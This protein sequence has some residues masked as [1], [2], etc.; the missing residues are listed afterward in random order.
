MNKKILNSFLPIIFTLLIPTTIFSMTKKFFFSKDSMIDVIKK[1]KDINIAK[2]REEILKNYNLYISQ[3]PDS[4]SLKMVNDA[5]KNLTRNSIDQIREINQRINQQ[6]QHKQQEQQKKKQEEEKK[7]QAEEQRKRLEQEKKQKEE[8]KKVAKEFENRRKAE[9]QRREKERIERERKAKEEVEKKK[10]E[11]ELKKKT[12]EEK[13]KRI[14]EL[15][16]SLEFANNYQEIKFKFDNKDYRIYT[17]ESETEQSKSSIDNL[18]NLI[19]GNKAAE[20]IKQVLIEGIKEKFDSIKDQ[21]ND[22]KKQDLAESFYDL[23]EYNKNLKNPSVEDFIYNIV[24]HIAGTIKV[25][26]TRE[27]VLNT[28]DIK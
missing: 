12:E 26:I 3:N 27:N 6:E 23:Y 21:L 4:N 1:H 18:I 19:S 8:Q 22:S 13:K 11:E 24:K 28:F 2:N 7:R 15:K 20:Q 14:N 10:K 16:E 17:S 5:I 25:D 9:E